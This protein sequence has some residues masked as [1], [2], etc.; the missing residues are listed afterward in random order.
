VKAWGKVE[1][2]RALNRKLRRCGL[3]ARGLDEAMI[4][5][6]GQEETDGI[7]TLEDVRM[8]A[9]MHGH[10]Q[11]VDELVDMLVL[12]GRWTPFDGGFE[13]HDWHEFNQTAS[14]RSATAKARAQA[15]SLGGAKAQARRR[16]LIGQGDA[17]AN[18]PIGTFPGLSAV[19][20]ESRSAQVFAQPAAQPELEKELLLTSTSDSH[21]AP[22]PETDTASGY[23]LVGRGL[24]EVLGGLG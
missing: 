15:G 6:S 11:G 23:P 17:Q 1:Y 8:V 19:A 7:V 22:P 12:V 20:S 4:C 10:T 9:M 21:S 13:L 2:S 3:A 5:W 18:P 16:A 24:D 14:K